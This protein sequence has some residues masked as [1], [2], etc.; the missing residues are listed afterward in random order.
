MKLLDFVDAIFYINLPARTDKAAAMV[1]H[2]DALGLLSK[3]ICVPG[4]TP[5]EL[6]F[7]PKDDGT[8][9]HIAY[10]AGNAAAHLD[11]V[12][13]AYAANME[14]ILVLEDDGRIYAETGH[15]LWPVE[16]ALDQLAQIPDWEILFLG[17][18]IGDERLQ[19]VAPNLVKVAVTVCSHAFIMNRRIFA[20]ILGEKWGHS[21]DCCLSNSF[22]Q[23]YVVYPLGA[24]QVFINSTDIGNGHTPGVS[25]WAAQLD[26]PIDRLYE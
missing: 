13:R 24:I 8:Y 14:N 3:T 19:L 16:T 5:A 11:I 9:D 21:Y 22:R 15:P 6:G 25:F 1:Q 4:R 18:T 17:A 12:Q 23:K 2:L 7:T 10:S 26:R 20:P